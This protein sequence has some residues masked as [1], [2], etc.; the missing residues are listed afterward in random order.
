MIT[1]KNH[2]I[3]LAAGLKLRDQLGGHH[4]IQCTIGGGGANPANGRA[5]PSYACRD[6][7]VKAQINP[8]A[9]RVWCALLL[10]S[11]EEVIDVLLRRGCP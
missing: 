1:D 11:P 8:E 10:S 6:C 9:W 5:N 7:G 4:F 3:L 2:K